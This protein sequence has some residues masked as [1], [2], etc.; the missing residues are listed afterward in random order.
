[1]NFYKRTPNH[2]SGDADF[3]EIK[4]L[5]HRKWEEAGKISGAGAS[6]VFWKQASDEVKSR[7]KSLTGR[8]DMYGKD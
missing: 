3:E 2:D 5:A 8:E 1:M 4:K 6:E 7:K